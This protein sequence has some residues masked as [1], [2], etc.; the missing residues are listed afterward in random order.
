MKCLYFVTY[1]LFIY[2]SHDYF[3]ILIVILIASM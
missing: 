3:Q 2:T 1:I